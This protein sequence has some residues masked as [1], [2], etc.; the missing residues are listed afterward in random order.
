M[1]IV[2]VSEELSASVAI[3]KGFDDAFKKSYPDH[4]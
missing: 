1:G 3:L 2:R 4:R